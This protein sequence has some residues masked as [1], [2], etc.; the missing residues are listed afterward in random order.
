MTI[1]L[2]TKTGCPWCEEALVLL[3][4]KKVEFTEKECRSNVANFEELQAKS[5]QTLTPT[6]DVDGEI[7]A[8]SDAA[9]ISAF[10]KTKGVEGF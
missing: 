2:Y 8:D 1:T 9:A 4:E 7:L 6:L 5:G 10:L 3:R